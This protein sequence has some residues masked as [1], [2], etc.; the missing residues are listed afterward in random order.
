MDVKA[1]S[2]PKSS[3]LPGEP[4]KQL[5]PLL[6]QTLGANTEIIDGKIGNQRHDYLVLLIQLCSPDIQ[7][8]VKLA[9]PDAPI[10]CSFERTA[11]LHQLVATQTTIAIREVLAVD[12]TYRK[13][14]WRY[15]IKAFMPGLEWAS[16]RSQM[17]P[18]DLISAYRQLGHA[19]AQLRCI[20]FRCFGELT[21]HGEVDGD[22]SLLGALEKRARSFI[23]QPRLCELFL[24]VLEKNRDLF[25]DVHA[26]SLCHEDLHGH[27]LLFHYERQAW[28]LAT[29]LDFDKAWAGHSESDLAR[30]DLWKGMTNEHFWQAYGSIHPVDPLFSQRKLIYQLFWCLEYARPTVEHLAATQRLCQTLGIPVVEKFGSDS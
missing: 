18:T 5:L 2:S 23:A 20:H 4:Y 28:R 10:L 8:V 11:F 27:N 14:P 19:V 13:W 16:A 7:V 26:P 12:T 29:I 30:L 25:E 9:G 6:R 24:A 15:I 1:L 3:G 17:S 22:A 21:E